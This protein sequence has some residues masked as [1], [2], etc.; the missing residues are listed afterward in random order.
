MRSGLTIFA[1]LVVLNV[2]AQTEPSGWQ[3]TWERMYSPEDME[4]G[5]WEECYERLQQL[6]EHPID[7]NRATREDLE[8][9]PF[10]SA[11]QVMDLTEYLDRYG[12]MR[13]MN[14]LKMVGSM[15]YQQIAL[16]PY[17]T[18]WGEVKEE[19]HLPSIQQIFKY[20]KHTV[21]ATTRWPFYERKGDRN[22]YLGYGLRHSLRYEFSSG[23][24]V[25]A[26]LIGAQDAGEPFFAHRNS[27][28]YDTYSYYIQ[29]RKLGVLENAVVGKY[30]LSAGM[31][32][33]LNT[34]FSLG[35]LVTLQN[36]GRQSN[37][38][39]PHTSRSE[40]DYFQGAATTLR[41]SK[42]VA[43]T[44]FVSYRPM[45]ATLNADGSAA[46]LISYG[47]HRTQAEMDK[48]NNTHLTATGGTLDLHFGGLRL[49]ANAVYT[50]LDRSLEPDRNVLYRQHQAHG[51]HF[52]NASVNYAFNHHLVSFHGETATNQDGAMATVNTLSFQPNA[53]LGLVALYRFYSYR[54]TG[55]YS[56]SFSDGGRTQNEQGGYL[57]INWTASAHLRLQAYADYSYS[58]WA[59]YQAAQ[60]SSAA[61]FL[62]QAD[63]DRGPW[64]VQGRYRLHIR[65]KDDEAKTALVKDRQ[66]RWRLSATYA[67]PAGW[68]AKTQGDI[69]RS[70][71]KDTNHGWMV[72]EHLSY[73]RP[74]W[75]VSAVAAY[76]DSN[77]Y[78]SRI[79]LY[80]RQMQHDFAYSSYF[81]R[82]I[83]LAAFVR[84]DILSNLTIAARLGYT[85]YFDRATIGSGLQQIDASH[86][87]DLDLQVRWKF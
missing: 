83:R 15:D 60:S 35:K 28:G 79:Y 53:A 46:T 13:S 38:L 40:A 9:L 19:K 6:S 4:E 18:F 55:L 48:K 47:Y 44:A 1:L 24:Y 62:L 49:G 23:Q 26:G 77:A 85:N 86:Q 32:L 22:G 2:S 14:E 37:T 33:V 12:P 17:F 10:L 59:R 61:D 56:H 72:S 82:G 43:L 29:V 63:W 39:R 27:W 52:F 25:R 45:D 73:Q 30:K 58:P 68:T 7:L 71:Y 3:Q 64:N 8:Q 74:Q 50:H 31:G 41:L 54:Y 5:E 66:Q 81:G 67:S 65:E 70:A 20:G 11:Q 16:L 78:A 34:S 42:P 57:G 84:T 51:S 75:Q 36:L 69:A 76:F 21:T 80:E 87:T